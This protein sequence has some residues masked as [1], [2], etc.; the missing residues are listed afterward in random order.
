[1]CVLYVTQSEEAGPKLLCALTS[2][3]RI[4]ATQRKPC[5]FVGAYLH[6]PPACLGVTSPNGM[7][8]SKHYKGVAYISGSDGSTHSKPCRSYVFSRVLRGSFYCGSFRTLC[9][10]GRYYYISNFHHVMNEV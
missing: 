2:T 4:G 7:A 3:G 1:M 5:R 6:A 10:K 9:P 8:Q